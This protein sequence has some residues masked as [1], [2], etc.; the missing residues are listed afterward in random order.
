MRKP[1][2][3]EV[4]QKI[5]QAFCTVRNSHKEMDCAI[6]ED[7]ADAVMALFEDKPMSTCNHVSWTLAD[8]GKVVCDGCGLACGLTMELASKPTPKWEEDLS[9]YVKRNGLKS[10]DSECVTLH[11][12]GLKD[13]IRKKLREIVDNINKGGMAYGFHVDAVKREWGL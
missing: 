12:E 11:A 6:V 9:K 10:Y 5:S 13:F 2:K 8:G 4:V 7:A 1:T 3:G